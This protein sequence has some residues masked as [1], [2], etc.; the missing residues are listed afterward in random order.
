MKTK[1][2]NSDLLQQKIAQALAGG[3]EARTA[4]YK[5]TNRLLAR[6]R[7]EFLLDKDSFVETDQLRKHRCQ[8]F[9]MEQ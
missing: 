5:A 4:K 9:G 2:K 3:G 6:E 7:I 1:Q 8:N